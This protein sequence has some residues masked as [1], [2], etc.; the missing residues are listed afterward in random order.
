MGKTKGETIKH[1]F[2]ISLS[3][4]Y[5][6]PSSSQTFIIRLYFTYSPAKLDNNIIIIITR[7]PHAGTRIIAKHFYTQDRRD[8]TFLVY[9]KI[10]FKPI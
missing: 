3:C 1:S 2:A 5:V 4:L 10:C 6:S 8:S 7:E 9:V